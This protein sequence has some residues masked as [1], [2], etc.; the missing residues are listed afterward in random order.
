VAALLVTGISTVVGAIN[1]VTTVVR[2]RAPGMHFFRLPLTV[3]GLFLAAILNVLFAP[4]LGA[5]ALL[6]LADREL[7]TQFFL[8]GGTGMQGDPLLFQHLFWIF[9]HPEVYI[10]ILPAWGLI[11]DLLSFFARKPHYWYR[12]TVYAM[13]AVT[14]LSGLVYG[15]HMFTSG[16]S[17]LLGKSFM[18]LTLIISI[19][20]EL[21]FLNWL[22]TLWR[23]SLRFPPPMLFAL[24]TLFVFAVGGL[25]GVMLGAISTD[26][27]L[28]DTMF[29]VGHFHFTMAAASLLASYA[30]I[31]FW[32]PKMFGRLLGPRLGA[33]HFWLTT[34]LITL[35][36]GGQLL[37]GLA[38]QPR[39]L[40]DPHQY[41]FLAHLLP[42][43]RHISWAAFALGAS[44]L[45][46][47]Y[48]LARA[49]LAGRRA[50]ANPWQVGTLEWDLP[51]PP[52]RHNF[53]A[54]P[55]V[56]RGPHEFA[57][58]EALRRTGR[59]WLG[60]AEILPLPEEGA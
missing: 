53:D 40:W 48:N 60:Q 28:H 26:I 8:A 38:G 42:L 46:F 56:H 5:A 13:I 45:L 9:G 23:G 3:W 58:P 37:A 10:L 24:G 54:I 50:P 27:Y 19:P 52:P 16:M 12:G 14:L 22:H 6:L 35:V 33:T 55:A 41:T 2:L 18:V 47:V 21:L 30:G 31:Y 17:P 7:G 29:V 49:L 44:Q 1:Y 51:S 20:A 25:T 15:H 57:D 39:R 43:N 4:V 11:G 34:V 36:F 59:D 32:F